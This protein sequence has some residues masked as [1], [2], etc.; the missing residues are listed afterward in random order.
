MLADLI[1]FASARDPAA[2]AARRESSRPQGP[3]PRGQALP[4]ERCRLLGVSGVE[5][6]SA[7]HVPSIA[8]WNP[9]FIEAGDYI[10]MPLNRPAAPVSGPASARPARVP[11]PTCTAPDTPLSLSLPPSVTPCHF[12]CRETRRLSLL[13]SLSLSPHGALSLQT[14]LSLSRRLSLSPGPTKTVGKLF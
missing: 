13:T 10:Y 8:S 5:Q 12:L 2:V 7:R 14:A 4:S 11:R 6:V 9:Y 1:C 3:L